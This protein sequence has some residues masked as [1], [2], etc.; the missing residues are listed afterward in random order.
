MLCQC[1]TDNIRD[2]YVNVMP[3]YYRP[4]S[5]L[6]RECYARVLQ[7]TFVIFNVNVMPLYYRQCSSLLC[8]YYATVPQ[9]TFM[10]VHLPRTIMSM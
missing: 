10:T 9:A 5:L 2:F 8:E 4:H 1:T 7:A 3:L 6:L